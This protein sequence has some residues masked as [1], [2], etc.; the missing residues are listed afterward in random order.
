MTQTPLEAFAVLHPDPDEQLAYFKRSEA[1]VRALEV[2]WMFLVDERGVAVTGE[3]AEA[4]KK[5][6]AVLGK[7]V[8]FEPCGTHDMMLMISVD[9]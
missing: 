1:A 5:A 2:L 3:Y 9:E 6:A 8:E 4:I 7:K